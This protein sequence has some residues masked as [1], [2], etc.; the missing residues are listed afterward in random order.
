LAAYGSEQAATFGGYYSGFTF[1]PE[2]SF[3]KLDINLDSCIPNTELVVNTL[4]PFDT[5]QW[6]YN[7]QLIP[8]AT[9]NMFKPALPGLYKV[10]ATISECGNPIESTNIPVSKCTNDSDNDGVNDNVDLDLDNDGLTNCQ[11][12]IGDLNINFSN[13]LS[14]SINTNTYIN[15][16]TSNVFIYNH[17][18]PVENPVSGEI[19]GNF[20][21]ET[22]KGKDNY[23]TYTVNFEKPISVELKLGTILNTFS[24]TNNNTEYR[25]SCG[26]NQ[27]ITAQNPL[28]QILIDTNF[29]GIFESGVSEYSSYE[30]RFRLSNN[31]SISDINNIFKIRGNLIN[32]LTIKAINL[33]N[34]IPSIASL[35][36]KATCI[37]FDSDGDGIPDQLDYDSD[38]DG[39]PDLYESQGVNYRELSGI[40]S[41][42]NGIDDIFGNGI[43]PSDF[44]GDGIYDYLDLDSDNDGIFDLAE[45]GLI[46][47]QDTTTGILTGDFGS[48]G[49][50]NSIETSI[51]SGIVNY[52]IADS[53]NN[54]VPNYIS[55]DSD[56]DGCFDVIEAG[57]NDENNDGIIGNESVTTNNKGLVENAGGYI[58]PHSNYK[59]PGIITIKSQPQNQTSCENDT[60]K[61]SIETE[62]VDIYQWQISTNN[63]TWNNI[64]ANSI[65]S[66]ENSS[67]LIISNTPFNLNNSYFR[68]KINKVGN[69][70]DVYSEPILLT[71]LKGPEVNQNINYKQCNTNNSNT[72]I[73]NLI[74]IKSKIN[75]NNPNEVIS[76]YTSQD[77][78]ILGDSNNQ[79][80]N[81]SEFISSITTIYARVEND[82]GCFKISTISLEIT[83]NQ[84]NSNLVLNNLYLCDDYINETENER[85]GISGPFNFSIIDNRINSILP[86]NLSVKYY[87]NELDFLKE[88]DSNNVSLA[89]NDITNYRNETS[90]NE[91]TIW[92]RVEN[93]EIETCYGFKTFNVVVESIP[94]AN[95]I[96]ET[97]TIRVCDTNNNGVESIETSHISSLI[98]K[99][100]NNVT[101]EYTLENGTKL[102]SLPNPFIVTNNH[103][104]NVKVS[105]ASTLGT[106]ESCYDEMS[107]TFMVDKIP[108]FNTVPSNITTVCDD[109]TESV[110]QDGM[111][112]FDT[113]NY[114]AIILNNQENINVYYFDE[115]NNPLPSPL[116]N[117]FK[118]TTQNI[119]VVLE[120]KLNPNCTTEGIISLFVNTRPIIDSYEKLYLC[121]P[122]NSIEFNAGILDN[123]ATNNYQYQWFNNGIAIEHEN[124]YNFSTSID[125][126]FHVEVKNNKQCVSTR[127]IIV[128]KSEKPVLENILVDDLTE[129]NT[130][131]V[132]TTGTGYYQFALNDVA[133]PYQDSNIFS[134]I[135]FGIHN[136]YINDKNGCGTIGPVEVT[137][138][139][140]PKY[141][142]PNGDG[143][144][145]FW[146]V[147]GVST[148]YNANS[149]IYIFDR[150]GKLLKQIHPLGEGWN[151]T[152]N[153]RQ[154]PAD[155]YWYTIQFEDGRTAKGHFTLKR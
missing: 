7:D 130:I 61:I 54:N 52:T 122:E 118:S 81:S 69:S 56:N 3:N 94:F 87:N 79:I 74:H 98:L 31:I 6:Y 146:N 59:T 65:F 150:T 30:I 38:N 134:G 15:S 41:N 114:E 49:I 96:N 141:F 105:N 84:L 145:D 132:Q 120:N 46:D 62:T 116:P 104:V 149:I 140:I 136:L 144:H 32:Q 37:P 88:Y 35:N 17:E 25:I 100:Q 92:I 5:F 18:I 91:Q 19:N 44:D 135:P 21:I 2:I 124:N 40:D 42:K 128:V 143:F 108:A 23:T 60:T 102:T 78:A 27:T 115:N 86:P 29:D 113:S 109:E 82:N 76:F 111:A 39:I 112:Y 75:N 72:S 89:I 51:N 1:E 70:C 55:I 58:Q 155:D 16:F 142:T 110:L 90:P 147:K 64:A 77:D 148:L 26:P 151:G 138:L 152:Y 43:T 48:T 93:N 80:N 101:I 8:E 103:V 83:S 68:V 24:S 137:V 71:V 126:N 20:K 121:H 117:P 4:S 13:H 36:L 99:D 57:F 129:I 119:K 33:S 85:D 106:G 125:G 9:A 47:Y 153:G 66:N 10:S 133:G 95:N 45:S 50:L 123:S 139:G 12:S 127:E 53:D 28:N 97:N 154:L 73:F 11:E 67:Q 34:E 107:I 22:A 14:G 63:E 131:N